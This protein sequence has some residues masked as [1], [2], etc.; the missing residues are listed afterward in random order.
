MQK[1]RRYRRLRPLWQEDSPVEEFW[2]VLL[3]IGVALMF[4]VA[5]WLDELNIP[6]VTC[7]RCGKQ[8]RSNPYANFGPYDDSGDFFKGPLGTHCR[9]CKAS[10]N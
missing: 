5:C 10:L 9:R 2:A 8:Q 3:V 1:V 6:K 4:A 7:Q